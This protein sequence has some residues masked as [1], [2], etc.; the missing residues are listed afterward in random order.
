MLEYFYSG[1]FYSLIL[2]LYFYL[3]HLHDL[4]SYLLVT[5]SFQFH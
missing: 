5:Y 2:H 3:A 1:T 4:V